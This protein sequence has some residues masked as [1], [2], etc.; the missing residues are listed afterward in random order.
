VW[1]DEKFQA[2][3]PTLVVKALSEAYF[4]ILELQPQMKDVYRLG[5][6]L[7]WVTPSGTAL[8]IDASDGKDKLSDEEI[9]KL[10]VATK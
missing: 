10:F 8:V 3:M 7:V 2:K 6:H 4:R 9:N 5:N 1:I